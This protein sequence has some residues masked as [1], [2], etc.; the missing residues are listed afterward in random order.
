MSPAGGCRRRPRRP[1][2]C[3]HRGGQGG[4]QQAPGEGERQ[5]FLCASARPLAHPCFDPPSPTQVFL[6]SAALLTCARRSWPSSGTAAPPGPCHPR[7][8]AAYQRERGEGRRRGTLKAQSAMRG[9]PPPWAGPVPCCVS[10]PEGSLI[11]Q[12]NHPESPE[13]KAIHTR[14]K[15]TACTA[16]GITCATCVAY[17]RTPSSSGFRPRSLTWP[18]CT[19]TYTGAASRSS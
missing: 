13:H 12:Q 11:G 15:H 17:T 6:L 19:Y 14:K 8:R 1:S 9:L 5:R 3:T 18:T 16:G 10:I 7:A 2:R 4:A